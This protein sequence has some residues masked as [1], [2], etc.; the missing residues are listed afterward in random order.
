MKVL[1]GYFSSES[2][3]HVSAQMTYDEYIYKTG[4]DLLDSMRVRDIFEDA[5]ITPIPSFM[6]VG[7]PGGLVASDAFAFISS[8]ILK[9]VKEHLH[10]IDGIFLF[11]HG[12]SNVIGLEGGSGEHYIVREIRK[13]TGPYLPIAVV[14]DPH[15]NL[16]SEFVNNCQIVRCYRESPHT[17]IKETYR[18]VAQRFVELLKNRRN[19]HP[20]YRKL[21]LLL[22]GERC[23]SW[24]EPMLSIN[25]LLN[26]IEADERIM[27]C[28]YHIGYLRHDN[29]TCGAGVIVVP[30]SEK[31]VDYA[32]EMADKIAKFA[33]EHRHDFHYTGVWGEAEEALQKVMEHQERPVFLTDSGDNCGAGATG[34]SNFVLRQIMDYKKP[35]NKKI[36][37]SGI[38]DPKAFDVLKN[39]SIGNHVSF[40]LGM[41]EDALS[42]P[43]HIEGKIRYIGHV[44]PEFKDRGSYGKAI[45]VS[46]DTY[47]IDVVVLGLSYSYTEIEQFTSSN[48][49]W[50]QYDL[51]IAKQGYISPDFAKVGKYTI[52]SL[53]DGPTNQRTERL[54]F[55]RIMRPMYPYDDWKD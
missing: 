36:L 55:K 1:M 34:Y 20:V 50:T 41:G 32:N 33:I 9:G 2:N 51:I 15:G 44:L 29:D 30:N 3:A 31:D 16:S 4:D 26:E 19:I 39:E 6:A 46:L 17:D 21:P 52:M 35:H 54:E 8:R 24:D 18:F 49:D 40:E 45:T 42:A 13:L 12:A 7:H 5:G 48:I 28:S 27:S 53:T 25:K 23:C 22:G 38:T 10:E 37:V 47:P 43:I 11:L 14:M